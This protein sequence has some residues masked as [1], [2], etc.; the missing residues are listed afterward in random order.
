[1]TALFDPTWRTRLL[2]GDTEAVLQLARSVLRPLYE[3]FQ[4]RLAD[5]R[6]TQQLVRQTLL[7]A[8]REIHDY[9]PESCGNDIWNWVL[10]LAAAELK[11]A[12]PTHATPREAAVETDVES[13][14]GTAPDAQFIYRIET[15]LCVEVRRSRVAP[16]VEE[17]QV[18]HPARE[19]NVSIVCPQ[20]SHVYQISPTRVGRRMRCGHCGKTF[21]AESEQYLAET[22]PEGRWY[23][24]RGDA[25]I[26][27]H[28]AS[29][30]R[31]MIARGQVPPTDLV[32]KEGEQE[33]KPALSAE[34]LLLPSAPP[35][36]TVR[37]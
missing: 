16:G 36:P 34:G 27:P 13:D 37:T 11:G 25:A 24:K 12:A 9:E 2:D 21:A 35:A 15:D 5:S 20:C 7:C 14:A 31:E 8:V 33:W 6:A 17:R 23:L 1:M 28:S 3:H 4:A 29:V 10:T 30:L 18:R 19:R 26:G 22:P 32:R